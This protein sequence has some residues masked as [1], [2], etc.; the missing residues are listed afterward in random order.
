[1]DELD[2]IDRSIEIDATA[3]KVW[4]LVS[5]PGWWINSRTIVSNQDVRHAGRAESR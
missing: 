5:R 3:E 4:G 2:R 1:M